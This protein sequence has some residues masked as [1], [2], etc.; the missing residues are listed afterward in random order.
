MTTM[1]RNIGS[2]LWEQLPPT[3]DPNRDDTLVCRQVRA[4]THDVKSFLFSPAKPNLFRFRP[5]QFITLDLTIDVV[6]AERPSLRVSLRGRHGAFDLP[7]Y[8]A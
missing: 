5:G 7:S 4:E 6:W 1:P 2:E 8:S 3:W